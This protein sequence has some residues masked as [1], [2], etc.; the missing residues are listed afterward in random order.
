VRKNIKWKLILNFFL[1]II[2]VFSI[3]GFIVSGYLACY[4][5]S[6]SKDEIAYDVRAAKL[7][8]TSFIYVMNENGEFEEYD[9]VHT[10]ENRI[11][12][13]FENIPKA[14]KDAII[15][16]E[17]KRF[18]KHHGVDWIRTMGAMTSLFKKGGSFGGSTLTQQTIK[19]LTEDN[20]VSLVRKVREIF[21]ALNLEK[22]YSKDEILEVYSNIVNFGSGT[23]GV[24][25][26]AKIYFNKEIFE[27]SI[28]ECAAIAGITQ[29]P[30]AYTPLVYPE[31]NK[32][33]RELVLSQMYEQGKITLDEYNNA[34]EES[35]NMKFYNNK[36][37][38]EDE[39][40]KED[41]SFVR[42][43]YVEA[44]LEDIKKDLQ[45]QL[46]VGKNSAEE[47]IYKQGLKIY[48]AMDKRAQE[49]VESTIYDPKFAPKGE[50][51]ELGYSMIDLNGRVLATLGSRKEKKGN[52]WFD[53]ANMA[54]RQPGSS[55]KPLSVYT[56]AID[57][58]LFNYSSALSN[59]QI[60]DFFGAGKPGPFNY[61][62]G[63][64]NGLRSLYHSIWESYNI[65]A[66]QV[67]KKLGI[68][69]SYKFLTEKL[70]F[71]SLCEEDS[72]SLAALAMGGFHKGVT[73]R[74]ITAGFQI[75]GNGGVFNKPYTYLYVLDREGRVLLDNREQKGTRA[76]SSQ[77]ATIM[78][79]LLRGVITN[80]T[81]RMKKTGN[82]EN[83][84]FIGKSGTTSGDKDYWFVG[85][86]PYACAGIWCGFDNPKA[87]SEEDMTG[88]KII[89]RAIM[90]KYLKDK[91]NKDF[92]YDKEVQEYHFCTL[93][94]KLATTGCP[95]AQKGY[96]KK[97]AL[98]EYC[99]KHAGVHMDSLNEEKN[100]QEN[101]NNTSEED[102]N[103]E[104]DIE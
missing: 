49:I 92:N 70:N 28:A 3:S 78:N 73:V 74:E 20:G 55:V 76:I 93:T 102:L 89:W 103:E 37:N 32:K 67:L 54:K 35:K 79:K 4:I 66:A 9:S 40:E 90:E 27:C 88:T 6:M 17:D 99:E 51:L 2:L 104:E 14:M 39:E 75:F 82:I 50:N 13:D 30:A 96:Y 77:T 18:E 10:D 15:A 5:M 97:D 36:K 85:L 26:A 65:P 46:G 53:R 95:N 42:S 48:C 45:E 52:L 86:S 22:K 41:L 57:S 19:N 69:R 60:P 84:N 8:L 62:K 98:P 94:G 12:V 29:N 80:G 71:T 100:S 63:N 47:M 34:L 38:D 25:A 101:N 68:A 33:R 91:E 59:E 1:S 43:W 87:I 23:R 21:R 56:P 7:Q 61:N 11:W 64:I 24:Q 58:G 81:W 83:W 31:N 16:I 72:F 44:M